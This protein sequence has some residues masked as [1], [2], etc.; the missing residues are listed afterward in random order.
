MTPSEP[1]TPT[2]A[3][4]TPFSG[5]AR[6]AIEKHL[7]EARGN[8]ALWAIAPNE[9]CVRI[10][11][12]DGRYFYVALR[13][14]LDWVSGEVGIS[15]EPVALRELTP[16]PGPAATGAIG[17][18]MR[19]GDLLHGDDRWWPAGDDERALLASLEFLALQLAV[20]GRARYRRAPGSET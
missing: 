9:A 7:P 8:A 20:K 14:H 11:L 12:E 19:A 18:R 1:T 6:R 17:M 15:R 4:A 5:L 10:R 3:R 2:A 13:R 16:E